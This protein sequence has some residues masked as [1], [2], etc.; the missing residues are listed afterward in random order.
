MSF[1]GWTINYVLSL[2]AKTFFA[3]LKSSRKIR[4]ERDLYTFKELVDIAFVS[5][6]GE[7]YAKDLREHYKNQSEHV[8]KRNIKSMS[9]SD[10]HAAMIMAG[11][12]NKKKQ[13]MGLH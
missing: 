7:K 6:G 2:P 10:P 12:L 11:L 1:Q 8:P 13:L 4:R 9:G 5:L 3:A